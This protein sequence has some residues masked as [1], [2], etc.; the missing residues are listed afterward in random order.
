MI[1]LSKL[2][3][4][5]MVGLLTHSCV[6]PETIPDGI[7]GSVECNLTDPE[8]CGP[9]ACNQVHTNT[10]SIPVVH[11]D[12]DTCGTTLIGQVFMDGAF[13]ND[14]LTIVGEF[15]TEEG[16]CTYAQAQAVTRAKVAL[17]RIGR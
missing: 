4:I 15:C 9:V 11:L 3:L 5:V 2:S 6:K 16:N 1:K 8:S 7:V 14:L 12:A 17:K 13:V 10:T